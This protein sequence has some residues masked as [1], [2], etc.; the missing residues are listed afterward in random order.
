[1][2]FSTG[3]IQLSMYSTE[4]GERLKAN[5]YTLEN[6]VNVDGSP[7]LMSIGQLAMAICLQRAASLEE[8]IIDLMED[9]NA[10]T[11][12]LEDLTAIEQTIVDSGDSFN[13]S[14]TYTTMSGT[15][16]TYAA[17]LQNN[18]IAAA[19]TG[20][21]NAATIEAVVSS[22]EDKM[23]SLNTIS[24]E[25][26]IQLQSLTAKRDQTYDLVSN[27]LKSLNTVLIGNA[28]NL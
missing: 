27:I 12:L 24:Q 11:V 21:W 26:L 20:N 19:T 15:T 25:V 6:V 8:Q 7:R 16:T 2:S 10:N 17:F 3:Q 1:M 4:T 28:N 18:G 14:Q 23:D 13:S 9:M 5:V 22:I